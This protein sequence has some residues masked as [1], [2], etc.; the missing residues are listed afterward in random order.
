MINLAQGQYF[1]SSSNAVENDFLKLCITSHGKETSIEQH[2]HENTYLSV[3]FSGSYLEEGNGNTQSIS[4]GEAL[5][6][7]KGYQ[8]KNSFQETNGICFNV[9]FKPDWF[10]LEHHKR[11]E[12]LGLQKFRASRY[13]SL[14]KLLLNLKYGK[15]TDSDFEYVY[16]WYSDFNALKPLSGNKKWVKDIITILNDEIHQFHSLEDLGYY[17]SVHPVYLARA[18]KASQG[19]TIGE[20]QLQLKIDK[21]LELLLNSSKCISSISF[22][23]GFYDDSHFIRNFKSVYGVPPSKFRKLVR[24]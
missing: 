14:F 20:F 13:P 11:T 1:G 15:T 5:L 8:H 19:Y 7:P 9:E 4:A 6:R 10:K 21:A 18:F 22:E 23:T 3:L 17:V 2:H 24:G 12:N 16:D